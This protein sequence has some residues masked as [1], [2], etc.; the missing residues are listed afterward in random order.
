MRRDERFSRG[1]DQDNE[2]RTALWIFALLGKRQEDLLEQY[3]DMWPE[4]F[5]ARA[6]A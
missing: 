5:R 2:L 4:E 6:Q 3:L 1:F